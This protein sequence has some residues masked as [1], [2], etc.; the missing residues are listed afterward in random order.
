MRSNDR[1]MAGVMTATTVG[2]DCRVEVRHDKIKLMSSNENE[3]EE[4]VQFFGRLYSAVSLV[5]PYLYVY[6]F[7]G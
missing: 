7:N 3:I 6:E 2:G 4:S 5:I 1:I